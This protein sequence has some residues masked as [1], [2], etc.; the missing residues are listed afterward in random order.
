VSYFFDESIWCSSI[1][2]IIWIIDEEYFKE[3]LINNVQTIYDEEEELCSICLEI[4]Y[5]K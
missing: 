5:E 4:F 1:N 3:D 2:I